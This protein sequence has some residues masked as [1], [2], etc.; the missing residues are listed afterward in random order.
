M[1][2][3]T[4][5]EMADM[6]LIYGEARGNGM[7]AQRLYQERFPN[8]RHPHHATFASIHQRL[9]DSGTFQ[10]DRHDTGRE[11]TVRT[12][13]FE[14][15]VLEMVA[16]D[17]TTSTRAVGRA[18]GVAHSTVWE[19]WHE[20]LLY[21]FHLRKVQAMGAADFP[22]RVQFAN[23]FQERQAIDPLFSSRVLYTDEACFTRDGCFNSRNSHVWSEDNPRE[24]HQRGYQQRFSVN[25]WCGIVHDH[26]IGPHIFPDRLTGHL[27]REFLEDTLPLL[28]EDVP[29]N[30]RHGMWYMHDGAPPHFSREARDYLDTAFPGLWIGNG[31][32][33]RWPPRSPDL[34][35]LDF[36]LWGHVKNTVFATPVLTQENLVARVH[37]ACN[38][39]RDIPD[40][41]QRVRA[42]MLHRCNLCIEVEGRHFEQLL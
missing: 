33:I 18:M 6:H 40:V 42:S 12:P 15:Q 5:Q 16:Q 20:D 38:S 3:F 13:G 2:A 19:V 21:P 25:V 23:W 22:L 30:I 36:F 8:R 35:P 28:L 10:V 4:S 7:E 11:R 31:G 41:F 24:T 9:R 27:Y 39:V 34:N 17:P 14:E 1:A 29:L 37:A 26:I 32:P